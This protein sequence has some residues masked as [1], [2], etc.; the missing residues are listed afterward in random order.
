MSLTPSEGM[1]IGMRLPDCTF[2]VSCLPFSMATGSGDH[3]I[4][5][6]ATYSFR[7]NAYPSHL[8]LGHNVNASNNL[9]D[10]L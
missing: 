9:Y 6:L 3:I 5:H 4:L 10:E 1:T 7:W 8:V 2:Q